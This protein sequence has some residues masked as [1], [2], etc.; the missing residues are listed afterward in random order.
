MFLYLYDRK[1]E[2]IY[3]NGKNT[4]DKNGIYN[5]LNNYDNLNMV[6]KEFEEDIKNNLK[7]TKTVK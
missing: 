2:E 6:K 5:I 1:M 4:I 3:Y 7:L